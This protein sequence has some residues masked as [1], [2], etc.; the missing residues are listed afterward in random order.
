VIGQVDG[1]HAR[2]YG[3]GYNKDQEMESREL[4]VGLLR[5]GECCSPGTSPTNRTASKDA[6][7]GVVGCILAR[8]LLSCL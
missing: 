6:A 8:R 2:G 3:D 5:G 7:G 1:D 4:P